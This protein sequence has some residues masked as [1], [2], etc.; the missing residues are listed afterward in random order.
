MK[1]ARFQEVSRLITGNATADVAEGVR[2]LHS[3]MRDI[4]IPALGVLCP[5]LRT[6]ARQEAQQ[7]DSAVTTLEQALSNEC[8]QRIITATMAASSTKGN[9]VVLSR[10]QLTEILLKA[11]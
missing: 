6:I 4:N 5:D 1:L 7:P 9:P 10:E 8:L 3:L 11:L 2:W